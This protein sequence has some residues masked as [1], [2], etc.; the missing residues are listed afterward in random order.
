MRVSAQQ[1]EALR[2]LAKK[3]AGEAVAFINIADARALTELGL[4][5]RT[6]QGWVITEAGARML[7]GES[8]EAAPGEPTSVTPFPRAAT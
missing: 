7:A 5:E 4:A 2:N 3:Q 6:Q 8:A 1:L